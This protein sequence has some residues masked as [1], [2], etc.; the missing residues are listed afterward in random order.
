MATYEK[1]I[2]ET[3]RYN[4]VDADDCEDTVIEYT[5][6]LLRVSLH[7][8]YSPK[9]EGVAY[10][11]RDGRLVNRTHAGHFDVGNGFCRFFATGEGA[12]QGAAAGFR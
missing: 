11:L 9:V 3:G 8:E 5:T 10:K 7:K 2:R 6:F 4:V 1:V 12:R